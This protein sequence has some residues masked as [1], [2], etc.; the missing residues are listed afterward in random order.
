MTLFKFR[1]KNKKSINKEK[2]TIIFVRHR[3][4]VFET[5]LANALKKRGFKVKAITFYT[6]KEELQY[7]FDETISLINESDKNLS[8]IE[9]LFHFPKFFLSIIKNKKCIIF[10]TSEPN[11]FVSAMFLVLRIRAKYRIY[12]PY[13]ISYFRYKNYS[14]Y[15]L[16]E[17]FSEKYNFK[18]CD[19]I[20][21]KG[22]DDEL[23]YL[24]EIFRSLSK[25]NLQFLPYCDEDLM[26]ELDKEYFN[27]KLGKKDGKIHLVFAGGVHENQIGY[28][29][30]HEIF[31]KIVEQKLYLDVYATNYDNI[32]KLKVYQKLKKNKYF[33]LHKPI[34]G[35]VFQINLG[36][37]DWGILIHNHNLN[38]M[39]ELWNFTAY[40]NRISSFLEAGIPV[41]V[42][43]NLSFN[44]EIICNLGVGINVDSEENILQTIK[45]Y[46]Y[47]NL[48]KN[49][50]KNRNKFTLSSNL[51]RLIKFI[52][53]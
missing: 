39:N 41:I 32:H 15:P 45:S 5:K 12:F 44:S 30:D 16:Y 19:G 21:H 10:G 46:N 35:K 50:I 14:M 9:K 28:C 18:C 24:P 33:K 26:V 42:K 17:R 22:P 53:I 23:K 27:K 8:K 36:K 34:F 37:Y 29:D 25:P 49:I 7:V 13:D 51:D 40:S 47:D 3:L 4:S 11:W 20:I 48:L 43:S 2:L 52:K 38:F 6:I 31:D 1:K